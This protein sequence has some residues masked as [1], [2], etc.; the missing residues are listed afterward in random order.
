PTTTSTTTNPATTA[1]DLNPSRLTPPG[2]AIESASS[3]PACEGQGLRHSTRPGLQHLQH[4][5]PLPLSA[6]R[7]DSLASAIVDARSP[8]Q[9]GP[10]TRPN[11]PHTAASSAPVNSAALQRRARYQASGHLRD[12]ATARPFPNPTPTVD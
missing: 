8:A 10:P 4:L 6:R 9:N 12:P 2:P 1:N 7:P 3:H 5:E 11:H